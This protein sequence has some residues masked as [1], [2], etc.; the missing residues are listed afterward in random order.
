[1]FRVRPSKYERS[2]RFS[3]ALLLGISIVVLSI[4][5]WTTVT[6]LRREQ[7]ALH[8]LIL[9]LSAEAR[10]HGEALANEM[11]WQIRYMGLLIIALLATAVA[12]AFLLKAYGASQRSL[13]N[14]K[15]FAADILSSMDQAVITTNRQGRVTGINDRGMNLLNLTEACVGQP[16]GG[17]P[18]QLP[19]ETLRVEAN[20]N[21][22]ARLI[23]DFAI[24]EHGSRST[25]RVYC[26]P[27]MNERDQE[28]GKI[29]Q[30]HD[31]TER[32]LMI[33]RLL[34]MERFMGLGTLAA[35][36]HHEIKNPLAALSLHVQL[37]E[38]QL[39]FHSTSEE[40]RELLDVIHTEVSRVKIVLE[41]F[42]D[43][44]SIERLD[45]TSVDIAALFESQAKLI[46]PRAR[47]CQIQV[48]IVPVPEDILK[49]TADA[50]RLSQVL[51]NLLVNGI[52]AM[53]EGGTLTLRAQRHETA[54][55]IAIQ[56]SDTGTGI[57]DKLQEQVLNPYFSTKPQGTGLGLALC[58]KIVRQ[59]GGELTFRSSPEGTTFQFTLP[60][61]H[62]SLATAKP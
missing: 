58:D 37:L 48:R 1:M 20:S 46:G 13:R 16:L 7:Q 4:S 28:I 2:F 47:S 18:I 49:V 36:L 53:P 19:L 61:D 3:V 59:H 25:F 30:V 35:G 57:P 56:V 62:S 12:T 60:I 54:G 34:R 51:L 5:V 23:R 44:A 41:S 55:A 50:V 9:D 33:E 32:V 11:N 29:I 31:V 43:F 26:E 38:E 27:L 6:T 8:E 17:L 39:D 10:S 21:N 24:S 45:S 14:V 22:A 52:E 15:A 40:A 42:R